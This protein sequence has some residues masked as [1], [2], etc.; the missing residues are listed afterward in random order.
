[1]SL[2]SLM[3]NSSTPITVCGRVLN[4][5]DSFVFY[6]DSDPLKSLKYELSMSLRTREVAEAIG[7]GTLEYYK[8]NER[9]SSNAFY[10]FYNGINDK[11]TNILFQITESGEFR[12]RSLE[13]GKIFRI[14]LSEEV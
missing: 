1:M 11:S 7:T 2:H 3:N 10:V 8:D 9:Q 13:S 6:D 14:Q 5:G 4:N 12:V